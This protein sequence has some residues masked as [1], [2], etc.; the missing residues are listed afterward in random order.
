LR[1]ISDPPLLTCEKCGQPVQKL[2]SNTSFSLK[3]GGWYQ[4]GYA[5]KAPKKEAKENTTE[6]KSTTTETPTNNKNQKGDQ[7]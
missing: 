7:S 2:V 6:T 5:N 4:D 1:K 3:G